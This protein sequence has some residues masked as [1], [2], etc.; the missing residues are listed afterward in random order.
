MKMNILALTETKKK[1]NGVLEFEG[2]HMFIY[3]GVSNENRA[4]GGV[5][6]LICK[7]FTKYVRKWRSISNRILTVELEF[8]EKTRMTII[9]TY[10]PNEDEKTDIKDKFWEELNEVVDEATGELYILG[11]LNARVGTKDDYTNQAL[12]Q[13]GE[14]IRNNNGKRLLCFCIQNDLIIA[15]SFFRH[16]AIHTYTREMHSRNEKSIIDYVITHRSNRRSL[17]DVR[18]RRGPEIN[19]DHYLVTAKLNSNI[20]GSE[21]LRC[22]KARKNRKEVIKSYKLNIPEMAELF[23]EKVE[24]KVNAQRQSIDGNVEDLWQLFKHMLLETSKEVCGTILL[25]NTRKQTAWWN[26]EIKNQVKAKKDKWKIH[27]RTKTEESYKI[28]KDQRNKVKELV[29]EAKKKAWEDFGLKMEQD[30]KS[31]QKLF[32]KVLK[33]IR[34]GPQE[35]PKQIKNKNG[36]ILTEGKEIMERWKE[37]FETLLSQTDQPLNTTEEHFLYE[38]DNDENKEQIGIVDKISLEELNGAIK[39]LKNGKAAGHD[40]ITAEM[41]KKLG[42]LGKN[43]LLEVINR[44]WEERK[45]PEDWEVGVIMPIFKKGDKR[46]CGNYRGI[47]LLSI[48]AKLYERIME[49]RLRRFIDPHL[50]EEQSGFR[51]GRSIQD[52][53]FSIKLIID[54]VKR[55]N[56]EVYLAFLDLEKAFD[57]VPRDKLWKI[58]SQRNVEKQ[59]IE[60]IESLY[61]NSRNYVRTNNQQSEEFLTTYGLRQGGVLSPLLFN[62]VMDDIIKKTKEKTTKLYVGHN[63]LQPVRVS[64]CAFADDV[65][66][67]AKSEKDLQENLNRWKVELEKWNMKINAKKTKV[68]V[69][70]K[71]QKRCEVKIDNTNI[72]QVQTFKYLGVKINNNGEEEEEITDRIQAANRLYHLLKTPLIGKKELSQKTKMTVFKT[73]FVPSLIFGSESWILSRRLKSQLQATEM[74]FL[75]K[76]KGVTRK[77]KIRNEVI[78]EELGAQAVL[79]QIGKQQLKW[80]GHLVRMNKERPVKNIW[81]ARSMKKRNRGRPRK[82]WNDAVRETLER[83]GLSWKRAS[84]LARNKKEWTKI[85]Y[86]V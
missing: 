27:L 54:N 34:K 26:E 64:V 82:T 71:N 69:A 12:G 30:S 14:N 28:Y 73:I 19:S 86:N 32:Y 62:V 29:K 66:I 63:K 41:I 20:S 36:K 79:E 55:E 22:Y 47:T 7:E 83:R 13:F 76:I 57:R 45:I 43:L 44:A 78:R 2:E 21:K 24:T 9:V 23:R 42:E 65:A 1:G 11:D 68:L 46:D 33:S 39:K 16:K 77:D 3:S 59:L 53:I 17:S 56:K 5:G 80:F 81:E 61:N 4:K 10:G 31:N 38:T 15:N 58:L 72:D 50:E 85:V 51:Q 75:R 18:V 67:F 37:Y 8:T 48:A 52:H 40:R 70:G 6:C 84:Q 60:A 49:Q 35:V 25:D 74:K